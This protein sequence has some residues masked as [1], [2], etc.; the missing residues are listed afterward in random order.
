MHMNN[1]HKVLLGSVASIILGS[2]LI[3]FGVD[4]VGAT[5]IMHG[6]AGALIGPLACALE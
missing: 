2:I 3:Q 1:V 5:L 6:I 4:V